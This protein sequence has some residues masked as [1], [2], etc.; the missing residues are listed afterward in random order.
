M[1]RSHNIIFFS[2]EITPTLQK[3]IDF[4]RK[5]PHP[6]IEKEFEI[7]RYQGGIWIHQKGEDFEYFGLEDIKKEKHKEL[8][9]YMHIG[10]SNSV[11][12]DGKRKY[13]YNYP[14]FHK[15]ME[16]IKNDDLT[17]ISI[18]CTRNE[19]KQRPKWMNEWLG[20]RL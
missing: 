17:G 5:Q 6:F 12:Y 15:L 19:D 4:A 2:K 13:Y 3:M 8:K 7:E 20:A 18:I 10:N 14:F 16:H 9:V 11:F 1:S